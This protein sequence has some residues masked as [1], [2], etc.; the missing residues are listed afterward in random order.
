M[1]CANFS[2][3]IIIHHL[4]HLNV[5]CVVVVTTSKIGT[6]LFISQAAISHAICAISAIVYAQ[7][8]SAI[9]FI[10]L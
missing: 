8:S 5:L 4:G 2:L 9:F 6:G 7:T 1:L 3:H 10:S